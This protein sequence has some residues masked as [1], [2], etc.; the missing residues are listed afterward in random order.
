MKI[1]TDFVTNS[2]SSSFILS[3]RFDLTDGTALEWEGASDVGEGSWEYI[4][5]SARKSPKELG[6][7]RSID[8][9][10]EMLK[11]SVGQ[12]IADYDEGFEPIFT[13]GDSF[14]Q[15]L[16][17]LSSMDEISS[18]TIEG[19][20]DTFHDY[21]DG[22]DASDDIVKYDMKSHE[23]SATHMGSRYIEA[24]GTGGALDFE[25]SAI[26]KD[27]DEEYFKAKRARFNEMNP[28]DNEDWDDEE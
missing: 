16:K 15:S 20:E 23:L 8:E 5:L 25:Y 9:L 2:S 18:I 12:G 21:E 13:D 7:S 3:I 1:R 19:Y 10:V 28:W 14:I 27:L 11:E 6:E 17:G 22:P 24:E 4:Q 26:D